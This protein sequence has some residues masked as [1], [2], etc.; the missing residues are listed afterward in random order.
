MEVPPPYTTET[1]AG[2]AD[3]VAAAPIH[4]DRSELADLTATI[5]GALEATAGCAHD[6]L[7]H[8]ITAGDGLNAAKLLV[9]AQG[10]KWGI[11]LTENLPH[12]SE[13]TAQLYMRLAKNK[14][15]LLVADQNPQRVADL[16]VRSAARLIAQKKKQIG[17]AATEV[18]IAVTDT[19]SPAA[20]ADTD[21]PD[22]GE[23]LDVRRR[24]TVV[25]GETADTLASMLVRASEGEQRAALEALGFDT[26]M[27]VLPPAFRAQLR[28]RFLANETAQGRRPQPRPRHPQRIRKS[29]RDL[30]L[31]KE[32]DGA[33]A[34][35]L[36]KHRHGRFGF[37]PPVAGECDLQRRQ[38]ERAVISNTEL[39]DRLGTSCV[40][41]YSTAPRRTQSSSGLPTHHATRAMNWSAAARSMKQRHACAR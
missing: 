26:F 21:Q 40:G 34:I 15:A 27:R 2:K 18:V 8:A 33:S 24:H 22:S 38:T 7:L 4:T 30:V 6:A 28:E 23:D 11:W 39:V 19:G 16:S 1:G 12:L 13:R 10:K 25:N 31:T 9:R 5:A 17:R 32:E 29:A 37:R 3:D 20:E 14:S 41:T 35:E 36:R